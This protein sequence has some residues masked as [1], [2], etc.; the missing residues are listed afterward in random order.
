MQGVRLVP[1]YERTTSAHN[2]RVAP[3]SGFSHNLLSE[4]QHLQSG[5]EGW[6]G[7]GRHPGG[8]IQRYGHFHWPRPYRSQ[9]AI[10][11]RPRAFVQVLNLEARQ[12]QTAGD[13]SDQG[14]IEEVGAKLLSHDL[15]DRLPSCSEFPSDRYDH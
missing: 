14:A 8:Q 9:D 6:I 10:E 1:Q 3:T 12:V 5:I 2:H 4:A 15:P 13:L 7:V 11:Q